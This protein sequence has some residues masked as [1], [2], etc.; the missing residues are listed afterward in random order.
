MPAWLAASAVYFLYITAMAILMRGIALPARLRTIG[1]AAAGAA[2]TAAVSRAPALPRIWVL[3]PAV[4]LLAYWSTGALF[5]APMPKVEGALRWFDE[6]W[7]IRA[8]AASLPPALATFLEFAY[9]GVYPLIPIALVLHLAFAEHPD[10]DR[11]WSVVL[12]T[13]FICFAALPWLQTRPPRS[14]EA[15]DPWRSAFRGFNLRVM[16][17]A[18][19]RANTFPSG[20]AAEALAVALLVR[21]APW[22]IVLWMVFSAAAISAGAV[23]GRYHYALDALTGWVVALAV[24]LAVD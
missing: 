6:R 8:L 13:D 24:W 3:P 23:L 12:I 14:I 17:I 16:H 2:A 21:D 18:S 4:L 1:L 22:P 19:I 9:T 5:T 7:R 20:H 15:C 11:F 10:P